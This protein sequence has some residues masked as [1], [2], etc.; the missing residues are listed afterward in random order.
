CEMLRE[1]SLDIESIGFKLG[2]TERRSF[3]QAFQK[4]Q[5]QTPSSY[6]KK[7]ATKNPDR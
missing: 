6:R 5:G 4:W 7:A 3:T 1:G 2:F